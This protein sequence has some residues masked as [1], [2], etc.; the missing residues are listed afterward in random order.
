MKLAEFL[1]LGESSHSRMKT[2]LFSLLQEGFCGPASN[3]GLLVEYHLVEETGA[4]EVLFVRLVLNTHAGICIPGL[5]FV[6]DTSADASE[7][8]DRAHG[9]L[10]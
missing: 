5:V 9:C 8:Q 3:G 7:G 1:S 4:F 10:L 2:E 6:V